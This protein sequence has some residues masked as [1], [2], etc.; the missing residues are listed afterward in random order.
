MGK[1]TLSK[2]SLANQ[3]PAIL[4]RGLED[5]CCRYVKDSMSVQAFPGLSSIGAERR[6]VPVADPGFGQGGGP[7]DRGAQF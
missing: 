6:W 1:V 7:I 2:Q 3:K 5:V 4:I